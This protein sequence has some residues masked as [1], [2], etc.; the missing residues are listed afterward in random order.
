MKY[1]YINELESDSQVKRQIRMFN[2][3][4][5]LADSTYVNLIEWLCMG[6]SIHPGYDDSF[7]KQKI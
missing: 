3:K 4:F 1:G 6:N 5:L 2:G 7:L